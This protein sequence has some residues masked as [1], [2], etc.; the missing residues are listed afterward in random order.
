MQ[1]RNVN[2]LPP[3]PSPAEISFHEWDVLGHSNP[4]RSTVHSLILRQKA[5]TD[6]GP[7][8]VAELYMATPGVQREEFNQIFNEARSST[9][10]LQ[11]ERN[12]WTYCW[13]SLYLWKKKL[14]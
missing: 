6:A 4:C 14:E 12:V 9:S 13:L 3:Y 5:K 2:G 8:S 1:L 10:Q 11:W 7:G